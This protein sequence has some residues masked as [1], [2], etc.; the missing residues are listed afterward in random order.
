MGLNG[1]VNGKI[2]QIWLG[3]VKEQCLSSQQ[4][5]FLHL[6]GFPISATV[7]SFWSV[8]IGI[9]AGLHPYKGQGDMNFFF[10]NCFNVSYFDL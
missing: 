4:L 8:K 7:I 3:S 2:E 9:S 5:E 10:K 1:G 6:N